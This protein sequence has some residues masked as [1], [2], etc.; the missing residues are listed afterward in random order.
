MAELPK[1]SHLLGNQVE[2]GLYLT[3]GQGGLTPPP[4]EVVDPPESS[5]EPLWGSTLTPLTTHRFH[6]LAKPVYLCITICR[7]P[8]WQPPFPL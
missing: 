4:Q 7:L 1:F 8:I 2:A 3:V 5:A 6:F